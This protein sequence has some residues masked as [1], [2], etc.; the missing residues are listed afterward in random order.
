MNKKFTPRL[1]IALLLLAFSPVLLASSYRVEVLVFAHKQPS[2]EIFTQT[3]STLKPPAQSAEIGSSNDSGEIALAEEPLSGLN[4][5]YQKLSQQANYEI[6]LK[7]AWVQTITA[8]QPTPAAHIQN[9]ELTM[10]GYVSLITNGAMTMQV[11]VEYM[12]TRDS[13]NQQDYATPIIYRLNEKR[14]LKF[15]ESHYFDHP[16][17]G[18]ILLVTPL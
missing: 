16:V 8:D 5:A 11:D 7:K 9:A 12:S 4:E 15:N 13:R 14:P 1:T 2:T 17:I 6:L 18:V 10:N 3:R